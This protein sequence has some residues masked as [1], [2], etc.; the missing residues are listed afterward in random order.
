[1]AKWDQRD[2]RWIVE[3][4]PDGTNVNNWHWYVQLFRLHSASPSDRTGFAKLASTTRTSHPN[5]LPRLDSV[6]YESDSVILHYSKKP[7]PSNGSLVLSSPPPPF[8]GILV[9]KK[10][11]KLR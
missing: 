5:H 4:R 10:K 2:P 1:M 8:V 7:T 6:S 11:K 9:W 3:V